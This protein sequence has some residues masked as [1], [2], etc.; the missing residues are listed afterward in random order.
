MLCI[1][2]QNDMQPIDRFAHRCNS[3]NLSYFSSPLPDKGLTPTEIEIIQDMRSILNDPSVDLDD[4]LAAQVTIKEV[5]S[6]KLN[7]IDLN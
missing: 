3:C 1:I 6:K 4:K 2:C 7:Y 5:L